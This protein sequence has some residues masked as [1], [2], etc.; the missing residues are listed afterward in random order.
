MAGSFAGA[1]SAALAK[2]EAQLAAG[3]VRKDDPR[4]RLVAARKA[5][6]CVYQTSTPAPQPRK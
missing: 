3:S 1:P 2:L 6:R 5:T 4:L